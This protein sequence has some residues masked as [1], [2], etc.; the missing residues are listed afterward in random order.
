VR[1]IISR[2]GFDSGY[3]GV[4]SPILPDGRMVSLPIPT[5]DSPTVFGDIV[6]DGINLG[7]LVVDLTRGR[8]D[9]NEPTHLDPDLDPG[10]LRVAPP[11][12]NPWAFHQ[13]QPPQTSPP[14]R[15]PTAPLR[16][17]HIP[18]SARETM[19]ANNRMYTDQK[20]VQIPWEY[21]LGQLSESIL[22]NLI[23]FHRAGIKKD[24]IKLV[25]GRDG[26]TVIGGGAVFYTPVERKLSED[27]G[28]ELFAHV[29]FVLT[30]W[31][32]G[33]IPSERIEQICAKN[34]VDHKIKV[35]RSAL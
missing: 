9:R 23:A 33:E 34:R 15:S 8:I 7:D 32:K 24:D 3:G 17:A 14:P 2:K 20:G 6:R 19:S 28:K 10:A 30:K 22:A 29:Q 21:F 31:E 26:G 5:D 16:A 12:P 27:D 13:R 35:I 1:V 4:P 25:V 18:L 11:C